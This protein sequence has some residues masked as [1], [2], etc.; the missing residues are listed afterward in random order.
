[1]NTI[2]R[3]VEFFYPT[4]CL[5]CLKS[6]AVVHLDCQQELPY[7]KEPFCHRCSAVLTGK[8]CHS[9]LCRLPEND[10]G[11]T[12]VRS[13][14]WHDGAGREAVLRLKYKGVASLR[15]W[16]A[17][18]VSK[19][20]DRYQL[21]GYFQVVIPV[22][23]HAQRLKTR[24]YNQAGIVA[25]ALAKKQNFFVYSP[26]LERVK[27]TQTQVKLSGQQRSRNVK[28]AFQWTGENLSGKQVLLFDDVCTTGSTLNECARALKVAGAGEVWAV[29]LTREVV[30]QA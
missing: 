21:A 5:V 4:R 7:V 22:P 12:A 17:E 14:F 16:A 8:H 10:L 3:L 20:L 23:L 15:D 11:L 30:R 6:G 26:Y 13:V 27:S 25:E 29:T 1:M 9:T 19:A 18:E 2:E 28:D 24:G